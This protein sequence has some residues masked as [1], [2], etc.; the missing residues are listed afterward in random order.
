MTNQT[1][2]SSCSC[3]SSGELNRNIRRSFLVGKG[4]RGICSCSFLEKGSQACETCESNTAQTDKVEHFRVFD[5]TNNAFPRIPVV[6]EFLQC[7]PVHRA[8]PPGGS[9]CLSEH[10]CHLEEISKLAYVSLTVDQR[11]EENYALATTLFQ[12][13]HP[14]QGVDRYRYR[15][16]TQK[17]VQIYQQ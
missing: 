12:C 11:V 4:C 6:V 9:C 1:H 13:L 5:H 16:M 14:Y 3:P 15:A 17:Y 10:N 8:N 7:P 2:T